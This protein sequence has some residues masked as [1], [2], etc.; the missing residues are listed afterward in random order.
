M[1]TCCVTCMDE[2]ETIVFNCTKVD[3]R[4]QLC[5]PCVKEAFGDASGANSKFCLLCG[6]PS[7]LEM[8]KSVCGQGAI[9]AVE[10]RVRAGVEFKIR[11]ENAKKHVSKQN[12]AEINDRARQIFN[13]LADEIN[14]KCPRCKMS[15][16]DYDGCNALTCGNGSCKAGFCAVCLQDCHRDAHEHVRSVHGTNALFDKS[17]FERNKVKRAE[18]IV[19]RMTENLEPF[20]LKQLVLNHVEKAKLTQVTN[21]SQQDRIKVASFLEKARGSLLLAT[22]ND[23]LALL[24]S[25]EEYDH[26]KLLTREDI[27]PRCAIPN[28]YRLTLDPVLGKNMYIV[29]LD[30]LHR[31]IE[32]EE[33]WESLSLQDIESHF[34][35]HPKVDS[36]LNLKQAF[37]CAVVA[38][39][40]HPNL[41]Q[42]KHHAVPKND[43][44][45]ACITF[46][47]VSRNG[48]IQEEDYEPYEKL[49]VVGLNQNKRM[50]LLERHVKNASESDLMFSPLKHL[51]GA[52]RPT[53]LLTEIQMDVP[54]SHAE[55]NMQQRKVG[56]P[57]CLKT[58]QEVA[59]PPGTGKTKTIVELVRALLC[60]TDLDI[61]LL[62]ERNGAIN[63]VADKFKSASL[64]MARN[65]KKVEITDLSVWFSVMTYGAGESM[66]ECTKLFTLEE[67]LK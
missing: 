48:D 28:A 1:A 10:E 19:S 24:S 36:L 23:R 38:F 58:A 32:G 8:I 62:S 39:D 34:K 26:R 49:Q 33:V 14:L 56:H 25:P 17:A 54:E 11:E 66:G 52:G 59:G 9:R 61:L 63:A 64:K 6:T 35:N 37:R 2:D 3:C 50:I 30:Y 4:Y 40:G 27:S 16:T 42:T 5:A 65:K 57:L 21:V 13:S 15:F 29:S 47:K 43:R 51:I 31:I 20:E 55:L 45:E 53:P 60:C 67:K 44:D 41:Y 7:A 12:A 46:A 18:V 22:Q